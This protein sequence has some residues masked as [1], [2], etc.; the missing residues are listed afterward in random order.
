MLPIVSG[1][2][3][4]NLSLTNNAYMEGPTVHGQI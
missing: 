1:M 4:F 3:A 2:R